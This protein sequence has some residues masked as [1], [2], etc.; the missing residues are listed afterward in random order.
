MKIGKMEGTPE[1][2][3]G[4]CEG[5]NIDIARFLELGDSPL[6]PIWLLTPIV[7][8]IVAIG[9]LLLAS[10]ENH[11]MRTFIFLVGCGAGIWLAVCIQL[12]FKSTWSAGFVA[13][14]I[15]LLMLVAFGVIAPQEMIQHFKDISK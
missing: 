9:W 15:L 14:G 8:I 2:I 1:E 13:V 4:F 6:K 10:P 5:N 11:S 7:F 12:R 3:R